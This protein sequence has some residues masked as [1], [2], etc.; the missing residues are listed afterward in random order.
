MTPFQHILTT[1]AEVREIVGEPLERSIRKERNNIDELCRGFITRSP[2]LL[3][4]TSGSDGTCDVSPKGDAA[5][6]VKVLDEKRFIIPERNGNR[7]LD[8]I[9]N[10]LVNP[11]IGLIFLIPGC[12]YTLRINGRA[13]VTRDPELLL[14][15]AAQGVTPK[16]AIG[17]ETEQAFFHCV[18]AFRRAQLWAH[19][20]WPSLDDLPSYAC[21]VFN[22]ILPVDATREDYERA[23]DESN[24][25]LYV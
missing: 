25:R 19:E 23:I 8:G 21:T 4:A 13:C 7:R 18:K 24:A 6:F 15:M 16:L 2:F 20:Q 5:G 11:K 3:M 22:Q 12:D 17:V 9:R 14:T 1:E 10:I